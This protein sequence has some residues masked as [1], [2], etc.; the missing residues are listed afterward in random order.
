MASRQN[1]SDS[2]A[3]KKPPAPRK[4]AAA[5]APAAPAAPTPAS[6]KSL[7]QAGLKALGSVRDDVVMRQNNVI[8]SLLGIAPGKAAAADA[9]GVL[10]RS[11][12]A[13]DPFGIRKF[14]DVFDQRVATS[15]Q[16]LGLPTAEEFKAL[17]EE[18]KRL[19]AQLDQL[20]PSQPKT[21]PAAPAAR[22]KR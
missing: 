9:K 4:K 2:K 16:H 20:Q 17:Q 5:K 21:A 8:D 12:K 13:L 18:V 19:R 7:L 11:L 10:P 14:E 1:A 22:R 6:A 15:L 3:G